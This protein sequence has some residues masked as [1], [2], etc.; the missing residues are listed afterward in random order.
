MYFPYPQSEKA[1]YFTPLAM[2]I[3][4]RVDGDPLAM[5]QP[6]R[7]IVRS[8]DRTI[9]VSE[10]RSLEAVVGTS[11]STRRFNTALLAGFAVLALVLAGIGTYGVI[12]Y[13]VSQRS[14]EIGVRMALGAEDRSVLLLVMSEGVRLCGIGLAAGLIASA[15]V[16]RAIRAL[17][18]GVTP[19]DAPTLA[20]T[21]LALG[22]VAAIASA[23]PA[24]RA[25]AVN[26]SETLRE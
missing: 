18:V 8:L 4:L 23:L 12:S 7:N 26:P 20:L 1:A 21:A 15:G 24:R 3:V 5:A 9:P 22:V 10:V 19:V 17:L 11:V 2:A 13:G 16:G 14:H 25:L 6:L